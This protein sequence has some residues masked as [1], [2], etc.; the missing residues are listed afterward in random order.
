MD[1]IPTEELE[2]LAEG[3]KRKIV[4]RGGKKRIVFKC[5]AG[6][7]LGKRGGKT[8]VKMGGAEKARRSRQARKSARKARR[9]RAAANKKRAK[10]LRKRKMFVRR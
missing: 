1:L 4:V 6:M 9:K 8:C 10:S 3:A 2:M 5:P 7:K